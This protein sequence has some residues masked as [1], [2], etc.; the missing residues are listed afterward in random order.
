MRRVSRR[1][2]RR[3]SRRVG[4]SAVGLTAAVVGLVA[5][6]APPPPGDKVVAVA[7]TAAPVRVQAPPSPDT[8]NAVLQIARQFVFRV[9]NAPCLATGTAFA[10]D[11]ELVTNRHVAA[12]AT[13]LDLATWDGQDFTAQVAGHGDRADMN[14]LDGVPPQD[15]YATLASADPRPG[16]S[17][18][19]AGYPLGDQLSVVSGK[20]L[21]VLPGGPFGFD[22]PV[23]EISDPVQHGNSGSPL[24][25]ESG[26]VVGVV[27]ALDTVT[28]DGLAMPV[29]SLSA[30]LHGNGG[31]SSPLPCAD[32]SQ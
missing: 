5:C 10:A 25:D 13:S 8:D 26:H 16:T 31:D 29:S 19:V 15:S 24:L 17:V 20:V 12:G 18:W 2:V 9:R 28:K 1:P 22:A 27:F 7:V 3:V 30:L 6:A 11:G 4:V 21:G 14:L 23:L 32:L